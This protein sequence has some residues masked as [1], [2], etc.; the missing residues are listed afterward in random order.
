MNI[1]TTIAAIATP[2][3]IGAL[4]IVRLSGSDAHKTAFKIFRSTG[5]TREYKRNTIHH[6]YISLSGRSLDEVMMAV[7]KEPYSYTGEDM[8]EFT[9]HG[10]PFVLGLV[11]EACLK[12]GAKPADPGEFTM[13]AFM[14]GKMDLSQAESVNML[15]NASSEKAQQEALKILGGSIRREIEDLK[16]QTTEIKAHIDADIE[17]GETERINTMSRKEAGKKLIKLEK[18]IEEIISGSSDTSKALKGIRIV[19]CGKPNA[20]KSSLFNSVIKD[21]RSIISRTPGTTRNVIHCDTNMSGFF[22]VLVDT[23]GLGLHSRKSIDKIAM[24]KSKQE[25]EEADIIIYVMDAKTGIE[26][27]DHSIRRL[28]KGRNWIPVLNKCDI[29]SRL[30]KKII[31][32]FCDGREYIAIS[33]KEKTGI[34]ELENK[35]E[36]LLKSFES[37]KIMINYRQKNCLQEAAGS[38][39]RAMDIAAGSG[40]IEIASHELQNA[41]RNLGMI[42]GVAVDEDVLDII[43]REFCIG[44]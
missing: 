37:D 35:I 29:K 27:I 43:F 10:S 32:D 8:I 26:K 40:Y 18:R 2:P 15:I 9:C 1:N 6:G 33:C 34:K 13:R 7:M 21:A 5:M 14:N 38:I 23:A 17:W 22:V 24:Y 36:E 31:N 16:K 44:K 11:L 12:N 3:G 19:I 20:G 41:V 28:I 25:I 42:D 30:N 4:G 39:G